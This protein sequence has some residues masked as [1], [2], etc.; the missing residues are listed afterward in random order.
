MNK[1][2]KIKLNIIRLLC[3]ISLLISFLSI[4]NTFAKYYE[5]VN[6]NYGINIKRWMI[7]VN[8]ADI[9]E[10]NDFSDI[11]KPVYVTN[12][13]ANQDVIV[14]AGQIYFDIEID[15]TNV[16]VSF[17]VDFQIEPIGAVAD[18]LSDLQFL[19]VVTVDENDVETEDALP[20][21]IEVTGNEEE[22]VVNLRIYFEWYDGQDENMNDE[23]DTEY[24]DDHTD[25]EY[26]ATAMFTQDV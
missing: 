14:P 17:L 25:T 13:H 1:S 11:I 15:Y 8:D 20:Y 4:K 10:E 12:A 7:E 22:K 2:T 3:I 16:D 23:E 19:K 26:R 18:Q 9:I 5:R 6:T 21:S 24:A